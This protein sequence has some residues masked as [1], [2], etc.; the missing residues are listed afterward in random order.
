VDDMAGGILPGTRLVPWCLPEC[1]LLNCG[2]MAVERARQEAAQRVSGEVAAPSGWSYRSCGR[3][4]VSYL[5]SRDV[6]SH[7]PGIACDIER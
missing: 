2:N 1:L 7:G 3:V 4:N 5:S 6:S